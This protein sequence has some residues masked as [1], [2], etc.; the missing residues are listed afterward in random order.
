MMDKMEKKEK[1]AQKMLAPQHSLFVC[2]SLFVVS[3]LPNCSILSLCVDSTL[4]LFSEPFFCSILT[5]GTVWGIHWIFFYRRS[6]P[7]FALIPI[8]GVHHSVSE[9]VQGN[10][11]ISRMQEQNLL[12]RL[13]GAQPLFCAEWLLLHFCLLFHPLLLLHFLD[14]LH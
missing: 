6:S 12:V 8:D 13:A 5:A 1:V 4:A 3:F 14:L 11:P 2:L 10:A 9:W 7:F